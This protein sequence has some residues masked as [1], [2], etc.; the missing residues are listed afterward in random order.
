MTNGDASA[1]Y[2]GADPHAVHGLVTKEKTSNFAPGHALEGPKFLVSRNT[3]DKICRRK[4]VIE[5]TRLTRIATCESQLI[6]LVL[7][8][9]EFS[10]NM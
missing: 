10:F 1:S 9:V 5:L 8:K 7:A 2:T 4:N 6:I 3:L